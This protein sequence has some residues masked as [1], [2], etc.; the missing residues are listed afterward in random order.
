MNQKKIEKNYKKKLQEF[1]KGVPEEAALEDFKGQNKEELDKALE[2]FKNTQ[3][4]MKKA[5]L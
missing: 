4:E 5:G 2:A 3:L 1:E